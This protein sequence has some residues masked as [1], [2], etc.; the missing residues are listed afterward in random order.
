MIETQELGVYPLTTIAVCVLSCH[1]VSGGKVRT[2][3]EP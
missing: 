3:V 2:S 1:L